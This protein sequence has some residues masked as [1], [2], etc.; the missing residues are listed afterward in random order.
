MKSFDL[1]IEEYRLKDG[2]IELEEMNKFVLV[3]YDIPR[4]LT[5]NKTSVCVQFKA[6][7]DRKVPKVFAVRMIKN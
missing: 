4:L 3:R 7:K 2:L 5:E 6:H 1:S